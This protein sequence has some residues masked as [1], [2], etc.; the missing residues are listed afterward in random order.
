MSSTVSFIDRLKS[1]Q[2]ITLSQLPSL[3]WEWISGLKTQQKNRVIKKRSV[4]SDGNDLSSSFLP[5]KQITTVYRRNQEWTLRHS[6]TR[7]ENTYGYPSFIPKSHHRPWTDPRLN[8]TQI[9]TNPLWN[10]DD[11]AWGESHWSRFFLFS[12]TTVPMAGIDI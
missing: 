8:R 3:K 4:Q 11:S 6:W 9:V 5:G 12:R 7:T 1:L 2:R 10:T